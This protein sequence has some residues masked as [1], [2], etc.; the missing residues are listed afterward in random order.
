MDLFS[1]LLSIDAS[2]PEMESATPFD[3]DTGS[4]G[5]PDMGTGG[6]CIVV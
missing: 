6:N 3:T 4:N 5:V 1:S 2:D